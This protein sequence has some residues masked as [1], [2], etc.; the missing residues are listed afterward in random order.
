[1]HGRRGI[2]T[3][4]EPS[5]GP[6][7]G[8][9]GGAT[10]GGKARVVPSHLINLHFTGDFHAITSAHNLLAAALDAHIH[11]GNALDLDVNNISWPR[12]LDMNDRSLRKL[13]S[14]IGGKANGVPRET[15]FVI[16][17]A[18]E[19]M[20]ILALATSRADLRTRLENIVVGYDR[21][22][23]PV[24]AGQLGVTGAMMVVLAEA[25]K[26]NLVQTLENTPAL[27]HT[28][29]FGNIAHGTSS[30]IS[31]RIGLALADYVVNESGFGADLGA[32]KF[33][34]IVMPMSGH[35]P[36]AA[37]LV[38][39]ARALAA[40]GSGGA[41]ETGPAAVER[42]LPNLE[43]HLTNLRKF[44]LPVVVGV[45]RFPNDTDEELAVIESFCERQGVECSMVEVYQ[46][47][48][49]GGMDL[50]AKVMAAADAPREKQAKPL[51]ELDLPLEAKI[52]RIATGIYGADGVDFEP[53]AR[54]KLK[55]YSSIG[56]GGVPV[57]IAKPQSSFTDDPK[58]LNAP[59][60]WRL[61][62]SDVNLSAGAGFVVAIAGSMMLMPGLPAVPHA[63]KLDLTDDGRILGM[64]W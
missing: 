9:K 37:V 26:P 59:T 36:S 17:A 39:T 62:I 64:D 22:G 51:Y 13:V 10:G 42:G 7:F 15:G 31:Q 34:D 28:G 21:S 6:I 46:R 35:V 58:A 47:G 2:I 54:R 61:T 57:C 49:E 53:A 32:E 43:R 33:F 44:D 14:G 8:V 30:V 18:S 45:N 60:G 16:T 23:G 1:R 52:E 4:R 48:G 27:V 25:L 12:T 5:L 55:K 50:A 24:R 40:H 29:P 38:A 63:T 19:V 41:G 56:F 3:S 20:A 11:H